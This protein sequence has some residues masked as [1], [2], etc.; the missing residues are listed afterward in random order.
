MSLGSGLPRV[1]E[2]HGGSRAKHPPS[3]LGRASK[4]EA[5]RPSQ[6]DLESDTSERQQRKIAKNYNKKMVNRIQKPTGARTVG[7][8]APASAKPGKDAG[9]KSSKVETHLKRLEM[10]KFGDDVLA[11]HSHAKF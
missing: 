11:E 3:G 4:N 10:R 6:I 8:L 7:L 2:L 5:K 9:K 1:D